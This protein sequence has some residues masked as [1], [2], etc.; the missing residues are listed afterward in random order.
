DPAAGIL[1]LD[2]DLELGLPIQEVLGFGDG[3]IEFEI[4]SNR[5]D[6][7]SIEGLGREAALTLDQ[8]FAPR[9]PKVKG[10]GTQRSDSVMEIVNSAPDLC[11]RYA[12]RLVTDVTIEPSPEWMQSRLRDAGV[13]PINNIVDITNYCMLELGQPMHAFDLSYL[14]GGKIEIRRAKN[15]EQLTTLDDSEHELDDSMLVIADA[16]EAIALAGVMGGLNSEVKPTTTAVFFESA[17]FDPVSVRHT[18]QKTG[19]R[20]ESSS[21]YEKGADPTG[22]LR[23]L[24]RACELVEELNCGKVAP[25]YLDC[26]GDEQPPQDIVLRPDAINRFLGTAIDAE[27]MEKLLLDLGCERIDTDKGVYRM[28]S[29]R[30]DLECEAD[31][32][33]EVARFYGYNNIP[34]T[35][36]SGKTMT[37]GGYSKDQQAVR[38]LKEVALGAGFY[39]TCTYTFGSKGVSDQ[40]LLEEDSP[41]R[42][43]VTMRNAGEEYNVMRTTLLPS[44]FKVAATNQNHSIDAAAF[45]EIGNVYRPISDD[46]EDLPDEIQTLIAVMY[47]TGWQRQDATP[48][49]KMK[50]FAVELLA[51]LGIDNVEFLPYT[52]PSLHPYRAAKILLN[53]KAIGFLGYVHPKVAQN[54]DMSDQF[55]V[56]NLELPDILAVASPLRSQKPL[57]KYPAVHRDLAVIVGEDVTVG[58]LTATIEKNAGNYLESC[59]FFDVYRGAQIEEEKK[60]VA[61]NLVF[62]KED[63][64]LSDGD[65]SPCME[66]IMKALQDTFGATLREN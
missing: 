16:A 62:R 44:L 19:L 24:N 22:S 60:S 34:S 9:E 56:L 59:D 2:Q 6:C 27:W 54:F 41:L 40:I 14:K 31:L 15:G 51:N 30:P 35:L 12:G 58:S 3:V 26:Q 52:H 64:T 47:D 25:D 42:H 55:V 20:T 65:I 5:P 7:Y 66:K 17:V 57:P 43:H 33:E 50:G 37:L 46:P 8:S 13:R 38:K 39:E 18:S 61:F 4:T 45:F 48:F 11:F 63:G 49:Y 10:E 53:S 1:I 32:A 21:R 36:L 29:Y 23:S 28:P